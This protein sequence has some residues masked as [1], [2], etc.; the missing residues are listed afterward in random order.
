M[1]QLRFVNAIMT[2]ELHAWLYSLCPYTL[3]MQFFMLLQVTKLLS[4]ETS[5]HLHESIYMMEYSKNLR[6]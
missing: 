6:E 1:L 2:K 5:A 3:L 4:L